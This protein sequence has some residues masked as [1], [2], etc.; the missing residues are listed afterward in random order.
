[1]AQLVL[2]LHVVGNLLWIGSI[3]AVGALLAAPIGSAAERGTLARWLYRRVAN[4]A[5]GLSL[6]MGLARL[7]LIPDLLKSHYMHAKLTLAVFVIG[8]HHVLGARSRKMAASTATS[9]GPAAAMSAGI[10]AVAVG[11]VVLVILKPF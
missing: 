10:V 1:M 7:A 6:L 8:L 4:P 11:I 3:V 2:V 9:A 5:L